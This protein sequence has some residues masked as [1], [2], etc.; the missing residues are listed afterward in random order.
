MELQSDD[1][2]RCYHKFRVGS[3]FEYI[4]G[5]NY[6]IGKI[7]KIQSKPFGGNDIWY[8]FDIVYQEG[9]EDFGAFFGVESQISRDSQIV[10]E[11]DVIVE[12]I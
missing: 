10:S 9:N 12:L 6:L 7:N 4:E 11:D 1:L 8:Y 5:Q 3:F 2:S